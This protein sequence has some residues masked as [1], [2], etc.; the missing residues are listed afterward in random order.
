MTPAT[1]REI[2]LRERPVGTPTDN[3][4]EFAESP[5]RPPGDGEILVRN[6]WMSVDPYM[7]GRM[8]DRR[9][10][11]PPFAV[12][13][14][15]DGGAIGQVV[16]SR[17][18]R[19]AQGDYVLSMNGW[20]ECFTSDGRGIGKV[21][22]RLAPVQTYLG[23]L[24]M[25]GLTAYAGLLK[26]GEA[27]PGETVFVSGAAG[28][29]GSIVCQIAK[30]KGCRVVGSAGSDDKIAWLKTEAGIDDAINYRQSSNLTADVAKTCPGGIDVY[31]ENVGGPILDAALANMNDFG[32]VVVCGLI[33]QYNATRPEPG[34]SN[35]AFV[36]PRRLKI[37]GFI[38]TDHADLRDQFLADMSGWIRAGKLKWTETVV[39]GIE[40]A[41]RAF[42]G[43]FSGDNTGK[44]LVKIGPDPAM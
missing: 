26:V 39:A 20:R 32:R 9:S 27:K 43:L 22:P 3:T 13:Q 8:Y 25:P 29:V 30:I 42:L 7:R 19:F 6:I 40:N 4:F 37:Q 38:V 34:P 41:P 17:N 15:L 14:P 31:F 28:A 10:Y 2:R 33:A 24:G 23:T 1:S 35:F 44:M 36:I 18:P 21:D 5:V 16:E 12:G 11:V